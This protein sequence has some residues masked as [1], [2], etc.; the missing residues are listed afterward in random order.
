MRLF[1]SLLR[2]QLAL[3]IESAQGFLRGRLHFG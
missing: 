1:G 2:V 3:R